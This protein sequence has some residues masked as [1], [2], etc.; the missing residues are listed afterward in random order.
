MAELDECGV[1]NGDGI[2][3][4]ACDCS[5][6]PYSYLSDTYLY[7]SNSSEDCNDISQFEYDINNPEYVW[8]FNEDGTIDD[9]QNSPLSYF[10]CGGNIFVSESQTTELTILENGWLAGCANGVSPIVL[11]LDI[12][13]CTDEL[14]VNYNEEATSDDGTCDYETAIDYELDLHFGANL[15]SFYALPD[16]TSLAN[17]LSSLDGVVT[18]IIGEGVAASPNPVLGW[19][20]SLTSIDPLSGYWIKVDQAALLS[21]ENANLTDPSALYNLRFGA[22]LISFPSLNPVPI[23]DAIPDDVEGNFLGIIGEGVAASPNPVLG[24]VGSLSNF[25]GGKGYWAK[26]DQGISFSFDTSSSDARLISDLTFDLPYIQST[27]QAFYFIEDIDVSGYGELEFGNLIKAYNNG[28]LVGQREWNG[29]YTDIPAMGND[30]SLETAGYC[31]VGD[32]IEFTITLNDGIEYSLNGM[33]PGWASNEIYSISSLQID[34]AELVPSQIMIVG[35]YPNPFN[36]STAIS[37]QINQE[38]DVNISIFNLNGQLVAELFNGSQDI[39]I[40]Q[41]DFNG[42]GLSSGM[43]I[44]K[45]SNQS[46]IHTQKI[47]LMK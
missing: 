46:E 32:N 6:T 15:V 40:Y 27:E 14:A 11:I 43:Y 41:I 30:L 24:W 18:G 19:V 37:Y 31:E 23:G 35:A 16:D 36:P 3:D 21:V 29:P 2:A 12:P 10:I 26:V 33:V 34:A 38:A 20:G 44:V 5:G 45:V 39:G 8:T 17:M 1:C 22:N 7:F 47:L 4:G 28:V 9:N 13:G 42:D 25:E